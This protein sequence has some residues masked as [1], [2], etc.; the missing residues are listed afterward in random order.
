[1][2]LAFAWSDHQ[3]FLPG[4]LANKIGNGA[5]W[6]LAIR[7]LDP[8]ITETQIREDLKHIDKLV[9]VN[10]SFANGDAYLS[11]SS[12]R[13][14]LFART[15]MMSRKTYKG[16]QIEWDADECALPLPPTPNTAKKAKAPASNSN[17]NSMVNRFQ[18]L[19]MDS[20][21]C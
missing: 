19:D 15:C 20:S 11:L 5:T 9:I 12:V 1:M 8:K 18:L 13:S 2:K 17:G 21:C 7:R 14:S 10:I 3:Y 16:L 4:W 6:N